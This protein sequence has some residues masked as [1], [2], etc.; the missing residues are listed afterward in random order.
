MDV[1]KKKK[2][3]WREFAIKIIFLKMNPIEKEKILNKTE[4]Q[5]RKKKKIRRAE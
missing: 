5:N 2:K 1:R 4:N 3:E